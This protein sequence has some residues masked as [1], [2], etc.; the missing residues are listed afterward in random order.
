MPCPGSHQRSAWWCCNPRLDW[1]WI[2]TSVLCDHLWTL[3]LSLYSNVDRSLDMLPDVGTQCCKLESLNWSRAS[4]S[5]AGGPG[6]LTS[7]WTCDTSARNFMDYRIMWTIE[8]NALIVGT[9]YVA[10]QL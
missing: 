8:L 6:S 1:A 2:L 9:I 5:C 3:V 4:T 7:S 10:S